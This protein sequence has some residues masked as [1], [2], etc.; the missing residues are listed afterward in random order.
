M[1][2]PSWVLA[3]ARIV[4]LAVFIFVTESFRFADARPGRENG[5]DC[6]GPEK[7]FRNKADTG[8]QHNLFKVTAALIP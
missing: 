6:E 1:T 5:V 3:G 4:G 2:A 7:S 8:T